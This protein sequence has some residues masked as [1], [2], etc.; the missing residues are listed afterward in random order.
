MGD[1]ITIQDMVAKS[2]M[3]NGESSIKSEIVGDTGFEPRQVD[4]A[5][6][7]LVQRGLFKS[8]TLKVRKRSPY[9]GYRMTFI[10]TPKTRIRINELL[11]KFN[12]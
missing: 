10:D 1:R 4:M 7:R 3:D 6:Q 11:D 2:I 5:K 9:I 12:K 8:E